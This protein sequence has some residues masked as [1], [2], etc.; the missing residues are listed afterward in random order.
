LAHQNAVIVEKIAP[1]SDPAVE[2]KAAE[3]GVDVDGAKAAFGIITRGKNKGRCKGYLM[4]QRCVVGG[5]YRGD[6]AGRVVYP[7]T[8]HATAVRSPYVRASR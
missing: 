7:G 4:V 2:A 6:G 3:L 8:I 1:L 5:W